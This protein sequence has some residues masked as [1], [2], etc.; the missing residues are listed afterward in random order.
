MLN[1]MAASAESILR[2]GSSFLAG[3]GA[4]SVRRDFLG[5]N[6]VCG[7]GPRQE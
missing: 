1:V 5:R 6:T 7:L 4:G 2:I 3:A